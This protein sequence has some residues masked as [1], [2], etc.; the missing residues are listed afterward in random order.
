MLAF[1]EVPIS[2]ACPEGSDA[3][4]GSSEVTSMLPVA[5]NSENL[6]TFIGVTKY[7]DPTRLRNGGRP[8]ANALD[9]G[10][11]GD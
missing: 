7:V 10:F 11:G 1:D 8:G 3:D 6:A 4:V 5:Y 9:G 2:Y